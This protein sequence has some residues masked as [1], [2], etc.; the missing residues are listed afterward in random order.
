MCADTPPPPFPAPAPPAPA[1]AALPCP[2]VLAFLEQ[3]CPQLEEAQLLRDAM[4]Q[5]DELFLLVVLGEFNSGESIRVGTAP[6]HHC[7]ISGSGLVGRCGAC[8]DSSG[9]GALTERGGAAELSV[10]VMVE[11]NSGVWIRGAAEFARGWGGVRSGAAGVCRGAAVAFW[12][13]HPAVP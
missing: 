1:C 3:W 11:F 10:P 5:L 2:Q 13:P 7:L 8:W 6:T 12:L 4:R 9:G